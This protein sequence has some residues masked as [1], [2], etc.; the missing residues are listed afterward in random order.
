MN[1]I[2]IIQA[3]SETV[4]IARADFEALLLAAEDAED[5]A[6]L[7]AH[8]AE[9]GRVGKEKARRNYLTVEEAERL[10]AGENPVRVWRQKRG[11]SQRALA[12]AAGMQPGY[13]AEI[14]TGR[15]PG[16]IDAY[17]RLSAALEMPIDQ[18]LPRPS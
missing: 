15:K 9:E 6:A 1:A 10:L 7:A 16:S 4:T 12:K 2:R 13:L 8:D 5:L 3:T 18:L 11:F 17:Q 14:E